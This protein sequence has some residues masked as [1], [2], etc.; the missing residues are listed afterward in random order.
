[1]NNDSDSNSN[2]NVKTTKSMH[3]IH[4]L[5]ASPVKLFN[6]LPTQVCDYYKLNFQWR[7]IVILKIL[8]GQQHIYLHIYCIR[9]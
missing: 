9:Q 4:N 2:K 3:A 8:C 7:K 5:K 1:M 6:N